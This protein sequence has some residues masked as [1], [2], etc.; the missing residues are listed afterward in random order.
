MSPIDSLAD[1]ARGAIRSRSARRRRMGWRGIDAP[2]RSASMR[3]AR[4]ALTRARGRALLV[5]RRRGREGRR[6]P[7]SSRRRPRDR[8]R[9]VA[10]RPD[11]SRCRAPHSLP[12][13]WP[14]APPRPGTEAPRTSTDRA[15][16]PS[17]AAPSQRSAGIR[18]RARATSP[19]APSRSA[20]RARSSASPPSLR[21]RAQSASSVGSRGDRASTATPRVDRSVSGARAT[22]AARGRDDRRSRRTAIAIAAP[23]TARRVAPLTRRTDRGS[24]S[25]ASG[26]SRASG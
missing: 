8:S 13:R 14:P 1:T 17:P 19:L 11:Q 26:P 9:G 25:L 5:G 24:A 2:P 12:P 21:A 18:A 16:T 20:R 4:I 6:T 10:R 23:P 7:P 15:R 3:S 22:L